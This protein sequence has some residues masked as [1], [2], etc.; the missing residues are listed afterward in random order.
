MS[1]KLLHSVK[2][3]NLLHFEL[4]GVISQRYAQFSK[5]PTPALLKVPNLKA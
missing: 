5:F 2:K 1:Q 4:P 3:G